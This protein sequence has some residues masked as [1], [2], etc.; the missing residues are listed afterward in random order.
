MLANDE[1]NFSAKKLKELGKNRSSLM[2]KIL[3]NPFASRK[4]A[5]DKEPN[6]EPINRK[7]V[8]VLHPDEARPNYRFD[9]CC[10]PIPGDDVLGFVDDDENVVLHKVS[11]PNAMRLKSAY[12]SR[13]VATRW[14]GK[15]ERFIVTIAIDGIDRHGILEEITQTVSQQLGVNIRGLNISA[16]QELFHCDLTVQTDSTD[17]VETICREL[18]KIKD[19][20]FAKRVS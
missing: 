19:V 18:K 5:D 6:K 8:Y 9:V 1:I 20:K 10:S 13:L 3:R 14:G 16:Q 7:E 2:S 15:A 17:T 4:S 11:C 12:G